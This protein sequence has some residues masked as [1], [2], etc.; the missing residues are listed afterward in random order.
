MLTEEQ[1]KRSDHGKEM[2]VFE[3]KRKEKS[4][5]GRPRV[6]WASS[7][8]VPCHSEGIVHRPHRRETMPGERT[9]GEVGSRGFR[10]RCTTLRFTAAVDFVHRPEFYI[11]RKHSVSET[12]S[13]WME[14]PTLL[15]PIELTS[16][17]SG[18][19]RETPTVLGPLESVNVN[20]FR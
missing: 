15:R 6:R 20:H 18:E 17:T 8:K 10:R 13:V 7:R 19:W 3:S 14:T 1:L 2:E 5:R 16:I 11:I 12:R 4:H 9:T